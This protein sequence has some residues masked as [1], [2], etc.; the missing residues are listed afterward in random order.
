VIRLIA[1]RV[2]FA[3]LIGHKLL[4][5]HEIRQTKENTRRILSPSVVKNSE[6]PKNPQIIPSSLEILFCHAWQIIWLSSG[7]LKQVSRWLIHHFTILYSYREYNYGHKTDAILLPKYFPLLLSV[8]AMAPIV[9]VVCEPHW[10]EKR[11]EECVIKW[12]KIKWTQIGRNVRDFSQ[13]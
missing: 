11:R 3:Y 8:E 5:L 4:L 6:G 1:N 9:R 10:T 2:Q 12:C 7:C 13:Q